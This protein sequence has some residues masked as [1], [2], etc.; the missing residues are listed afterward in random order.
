MIDDS[1]RTEVLSIG[2]DLGDRASTYTVLGS[3]RKVLET[4]QVA[5]NPEAFERKFGRFVPCKVAIEAGTHAWWAHRVLEQVGHDVRVVNPRKLK[6][7][8]RSLKKNDRQDSEVLARVVVS[9][10]DLVSEV[11]HRGFTQQQHRMLLRLRD[12][13]VRSRTMLINC[14]RGVIKPFGLR[15][16]RCDATLF[17][18]KA[19]EC[20]PQESL[21]IVNLVLQQIGQLTATIRA[22]DKQ[23]AEILK[24]H[25][26]HATRLSQ[27]PGV[28]P[29]TTLCYLAT[30]D[31]PSRFA[32]S[33]DVGPYLG[34]TPRLRES[35]DVQPQLRI[36]KAGDAMM[37][38]L[39]TQGAQYIFGRNGPDCDLKRYG[40]AIASRGGKN[41]KKRAIVAIARKLAVL[42]HRLWV[43]GHPYEPLRQASARTALVTQ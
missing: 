37:R 3:D 35:G 7:L 27:I 14:V 26:P 42:L 12:A 2:I 24:Q 11:R 20:L 40:S 15:V 4:G 10:L 34:L 43:S 33:R 6:L 22:Y 8:T 39:L 21:E 29:V 28:G 23:I 36:T 31:D 1:V 25:Y 16:S 30:I 41:A 38:R 32:R 9:D 5:T 18:K 13:A 19:A 17:H